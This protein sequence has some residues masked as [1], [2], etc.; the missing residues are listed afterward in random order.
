[1]IYGGLIFAF[2]GTV[3]VKETF[4]GAAESLVDSIFLGLAGRSA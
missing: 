4:L 1:L 3:K 2:D